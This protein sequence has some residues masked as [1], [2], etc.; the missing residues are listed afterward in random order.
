MMNI[1]APLLIQPKFSKKLATL[2]AITHGGAF[3]GVWLANLRFEIK[4]LLTLWILMVT[5]FNSKKYLFIKNNQIF[6][7]L[8]LINDYVVLKNDLTAT[9][10]PHVYVHSQFVILPLKLSN[11][12]RETLIL[13]DDSL[14]ETT[15]HYLRVRLLHPLT[16]VHK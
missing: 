2:I 9:I 6:Q 4:I 12:K 15:F 5:Y 14:D 7:S 10:L 13:F 8:T 11:E 16:V 1:S 3:V